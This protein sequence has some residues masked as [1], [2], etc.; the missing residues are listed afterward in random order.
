MLKLLVGL[1]LVFGL[2]SAGDK[3]ASEKANCVSSCKQKCANSLNACK[4]NATTKNA[5]QGCEKSRSLCDSN[6]VNKACS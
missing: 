5:I 1:I 2:L 6:C 3:T 4:K